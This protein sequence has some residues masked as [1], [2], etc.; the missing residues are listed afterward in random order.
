M[1][2]RI[3]DHLYDDLLYTRLGILI[4]MGSSLIMSFFMLKLRDYL[5]GP[6][7]GMDRNRHKVD[8]DKKLLDAQE[9]NL[10]QIEKDE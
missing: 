6:D 9:S 8:F 1:N 10:R 4:L 3:W 2:A 5:L 7:L